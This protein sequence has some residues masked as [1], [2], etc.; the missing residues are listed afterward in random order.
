MLLE[1]QQG[2]LAKMNLLE[3]RGPL[4]ISRLILSKSMRNN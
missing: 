2:E 4:Q 1:K 3:L